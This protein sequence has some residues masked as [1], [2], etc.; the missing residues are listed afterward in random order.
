MSYRSFMTTL[1][2]A[3]VLGG[4]SSSAA[5]QTLVETARKEG[6]V[7]WYTS[8]VVD[9]VVRPMAAA[10]EKKYPGIEVRFVRANSTDT[11]LKILYEG[12]AGKT[13]VDVFDGLT[14]VQ[15]L[16]K[17]G[18]VLQWMPESAKSYPKVY[19]DPEGYWVATNVFI[20]APAFNTNLVPRGSEPV[21]FENLLDRKWEGQ[22]AWGSLESAA[23]GSGFVGAVLTEMGEQKGMAYLKELRK[24]KIANLGTGARAVLD[25]VISGEYA[26]ALQMF[27]NQV[28][29]SSKSGAPV[30]WIRMNPATGILSVVSVAKNAPHPNAAK[31]FEDFLLSEEGQKVFQVAG[32]LPANPAVPALNPALAPKTGNFRVRFFT[33]DMV[34]DKMPEWEKIFD[35]LFQ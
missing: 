18:D 31:V 8:L 9:Q 35:E 1:I 34:A 15:S 13:Q 11:T 26:I 20:L 6:Q 14:T 30:E 12:K 33:P 16:K 17:E 27:T 25:Q 19:K 2:V 7:V 3:V 32:Y 28:A 22:M 4:V 23:A 29:S 21:T 24:Q 5:A 10:F